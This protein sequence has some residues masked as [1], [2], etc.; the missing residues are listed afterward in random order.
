MMLPPGYVSAGC[1]KGSI[2]LRTTEACL[3]GIVAIQHNTLCMICYAISS[4]GRVVR[5]LLNN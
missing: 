4:D 3:L 5:D 2:A 1:A